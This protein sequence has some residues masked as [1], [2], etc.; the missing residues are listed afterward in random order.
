MVTDTS[1][2]Y[3]NCWEIEGSVHE[4]NLQLL[5]PDGLFLFFME[6]QR[7]KSQPPQNLAVTIGEATYTAI[8]LRD[9]VYVGTVNFEKD[10]WI[11][12]SLDPPPAYGHK[13]SGC[14]FWGLKPRDP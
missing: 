14:G 12:I 13:V 4:V 9:T 5:N 7:E 3:T 6:V 10:S 11:K 8:V 2:Y 1:W